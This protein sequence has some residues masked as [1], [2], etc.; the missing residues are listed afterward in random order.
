MVS[1]AAFHTQQAA[2]KL[3]KA[4]LASAGIEPPR[5]HDLTEL[6]DRV[7]NVAPDAARL[8]ESIETITSWAV[9]TRYPTYGDTPPPTRLEVADAFAL[10]KRL[11]TFVAEKS[12]EL[13]PWDWIDRGQE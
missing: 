1:V 7:A 8:F 12:V 2:E 6:N 3:L 10:V 4:L 5:V 9:L 11:R 13:R